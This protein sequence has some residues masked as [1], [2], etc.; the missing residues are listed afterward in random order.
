M[1]FRKT[2]VRAYSRAIT[3]SSPTL[4]AKQYH[5]YLYVYHLQIGIET[6][7]FDLIH[8][9]CYYAKNGLKIGKK[10]E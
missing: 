4:S 8:T 9:I 7:F 6:L 10:Q 1:L 2:S 5:R 3:D